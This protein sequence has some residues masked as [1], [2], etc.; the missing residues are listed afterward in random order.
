AAAGLHEVNAHGHA[1]IFGWVGLFVMGFAYQAFPR[2]KHASLAFPRQAWASLGLMLAGLVGRSV[3][4]P[5]ANGLPWAGPVAVISAWLEVAAVGLFVWVI[6]AT[7]QA[8]GK[9]LAF[10]DYYVLSALGWFAVQAVAEAVY[11]A[12]TLAAASR[13]DLLAL[14]ATWQGAI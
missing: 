7:W 5:P 12:A 11:L 6:L 2:F 14:V 4:E 10:Y 9:G 3:T 13:E 8:A 1:Q